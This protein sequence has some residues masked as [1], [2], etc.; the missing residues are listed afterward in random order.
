MQIRGL[1]SQCEWVASDAGTCKAADAHGQRA[2]LPKATN[3]LTNPTGAASEGR[4]KVRDQGLRLPGPLCPSLAS[5]PS[6]DLYSPVGRSPGPLVE[7]GE[8]ALPLMMGD[9]TLCGNRKWTTASYSPIRSTLKNRAT[10][11]SAF[12][13]FLGGRTGAVAPSFLWSG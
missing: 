8:K 1:S 12:P 13:V 5:P 9:S 7:A 3:S 4:G 10:V 11:S 2:T 6:I